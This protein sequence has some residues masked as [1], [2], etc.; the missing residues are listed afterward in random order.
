MSMP[1]EIIKKRGICDSREL[2]IVLRPE[3]TYKSM[4]EMKGTWV[5][6][7]EERGTGGGRGTEGVVLGS[8]RFLPTTGARPQVQ[9]W[10]KG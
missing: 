7:R 5:E 4:E 1:V 9:R 10:D 2:T 6:R 8:L 3:V